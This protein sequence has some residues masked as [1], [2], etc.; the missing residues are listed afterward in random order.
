VEIAVPEQLRQPHHLVAATR[1]AFAGIKPD[2]TGRLQLRPRAS[3]AYL[4]VSRDQLRRA[5]DSGERYGARAL[6][7]IE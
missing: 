5:T 3:A 4:H 1:D 6:T 7:D 2:D